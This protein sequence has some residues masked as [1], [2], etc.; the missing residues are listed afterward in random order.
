MSYYQVMDV[1]QMSIGQLADAAGLSRRGIRFYVQR[2]LLQAP[3]GRGRG[4]VY[5][6]E[7]LDRLRLIQQLQLAGH[8]LDAIRQIVDGA[9]VPPTPAQRPTPPPCRT[10]MRAEL[11]TRLRV[12]DGVELHFDATR[13]NPDVAGLLAFKHA[14]AAIFGTDES[15]LAKEQD[16]DTPNR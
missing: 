2:G 5:G 1:H 12:C 6:P 4:S 14:A 13:H 9:Q 3:V 16:N 8:S 15:Q 11:W 7:H 10:G